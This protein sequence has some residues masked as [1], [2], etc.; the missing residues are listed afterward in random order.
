MSLKFD[1][2]LSELCLVACKPKQLNDEQRGIRKKL[3]EK[4]RYRKRRSTEEGLRRDRG[5][6]KKSNDKYIATVKGRENK[7][8]RAK[9]YH[10]TEK[11]RRILRI[12]NWR[13]HGVEYHAGLEVLYDTIYICT[14]NCERCHVAL[15]NGLVSNSRTMDHCHVT[16]QFRN[17]LCSHCNNQRR[18]DNFDIPSHD[19]IVQMSKLIVD[20]K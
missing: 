7:R 20:I 17:I 6:L 18:Q 3:M 4:M 11:G 14:T 13:T 16:N 12:S 5:R 8:I 9:K 15:V 10:A 1:F 2:K 19:Q